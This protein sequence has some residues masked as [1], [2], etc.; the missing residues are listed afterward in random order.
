MGP[1]SP[2]IVEI[3]RGRWPTLAYPRF[4]GGQIWGSGRNFEH[5]FE[6]GVGVLV[7]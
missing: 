2:D 7:L 1:S 4:R 3:V 6:A 5:R